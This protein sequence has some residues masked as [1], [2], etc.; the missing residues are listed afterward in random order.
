MSTGH[1][2]LPEAKQQLLRRAV[3]LQWMS[4]GIMA[5][6]IAAVGL[7]AGQS[8]A[9]RTAFAEDTLA[10]L[11]PAVF[12]LG[13]WR[14]RRSRDV[15]HPY[16]HHRAV[17]A[18]HLVASAALLVLGISLVWNGASGLVAGDRPPIGVVSVAGVTFWAGWLMIGVM[19][20][21]IVP[22]VILGRLKLQYAEPL[23]DKVL[24]ADADMLKAD[25]MTGVA[26]IL[27]VAGIGLG[28]WWA[29]SVAAILVALSIL[30]D[31]VTNMRQAVRDLLDGRAT[32]VDSDDPHPVN[33][34]LWRIA[35]HTPWVTDAAVRVRDMGH[36]FHSE[37]FVVPVGNPSVADVE[38]LTAR[39]RECDWKTEDTV[40]VLTRD[41]PSDIAGRD[42]SSTSGTNT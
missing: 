4:I 12:L 26:T 42:Q 32:P 28:Y 29:D 7:V 33:E 6:V 1:D 31:G 27:G 38:D 14:T 2:H 39:L 24:T 16:G 9:M 37:V 34:D 20:A 8:Q 23:H 11:P 21:S 35:V 18:G 40:V 41:V 30:H 36:V 17:G 3:R 10:L 19:A 25:W 13:V 5:V 22:P 15:K